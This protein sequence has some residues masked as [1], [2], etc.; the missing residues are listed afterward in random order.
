MSNNKFSHTVRICKKIMI[1]SL[2]TFIETI[3]SSDN[4]K[5][6]F[7]KYADKISGLFKLRTSI[8]HM[9]E[10]DMSFCNA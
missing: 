4:P 5:E 1:E 8:K 7:E 9:R 10:V 3:V 2:T 6:M